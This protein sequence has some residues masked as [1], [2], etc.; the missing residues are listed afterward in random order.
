[1]TKGRYDIVYGSD[2]LRA[3][4]DVQMHFCREWVGNEGCYGTNPDHGMTWEEAREEVAK[5]HEE[6]AA[7]WRSREEEPESQSEGERQP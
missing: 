7:Y 1:M 4:V 3:W 5:W 2:G 6:Q